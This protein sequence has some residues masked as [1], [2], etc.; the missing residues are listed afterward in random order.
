MHMPKN[1]TKLRLRPTHVFNFPLYYITL[2]Y[3][4]SQLADEVDTPQICP[5]NNTEHT[6]RLESE[7]KCM[8]GNDHHTTH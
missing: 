8:T 4:T 1:Y 3:R 5:H 2:R 7:C 6:L